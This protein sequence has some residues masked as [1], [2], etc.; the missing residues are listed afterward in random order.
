[1]DLQSFK[2]AGIGEGSVHRG[3]KATNQSTEMGKMGEKRGNEVMQSLELSVP[4][5]LLEGY[6]LQ[7]KLG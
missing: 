6:G 4:F 3:G 2:L 1:M 5:W 7:G